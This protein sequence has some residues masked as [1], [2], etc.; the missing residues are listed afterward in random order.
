MRIPRIFSFT[1]RCAGVHCGRL[2]AQDSHSD[3]E[4][5]RLD[6]DRAEC[7]EQDFVPRLLVH[8]PLPRQCH[9]QSN[10]D[11]GRLEDGRADRQDQNFAPC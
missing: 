10:R 4:E 1:R 8:G 2:V 3:R 7:Q 11:E 6:Q 5:R 9:K